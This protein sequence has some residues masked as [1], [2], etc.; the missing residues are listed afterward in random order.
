MEQME[1]LYAPFTAPFMTA[2][3]PTPGPYKNSVFTDT[4][5]PPR[6]AFGEEG[7]ISFQPGD[8][9]LDF[10]AGIR[11]GRSHGHRHVH[12]QTQVAP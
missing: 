10:S 7:K 8:F 2:I 1:G 6:F 12:H 11:Y 4:Q 5:R 3:T 9:G